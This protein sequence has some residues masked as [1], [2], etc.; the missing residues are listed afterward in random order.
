[1]LQRRLRKKI[2]R[3]CGRSTVHR[4]IV[5]EALDEKKLIGNAKGKISS[6]VISISNIY[7]VTSVPLLSTISSMTFQ[8]FFDMKTFVLS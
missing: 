4:T 6:A 7:V 5:P 2:V 1:M 3:L 8:F